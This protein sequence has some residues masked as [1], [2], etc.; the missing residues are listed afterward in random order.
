LVC[1]H[2]DKLYY[3]VDRQM[4]PDRIEATAPRTT[5]ESL[6]GFRGFRKKG[7]SH[8]GQALQACAVSNREPE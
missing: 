1:Y 2:L 3:Q 8:V 7:T 5:K 4:V 6:T